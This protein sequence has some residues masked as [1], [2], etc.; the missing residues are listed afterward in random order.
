MKPLLLRPEAP[1]PAGDLR[2]K[3]E[4]ALGGARGRPL[5]SPRSA[6]MTPTRLIFG[7]LC[8]LATSCVPMTMSASPLAMASSSSRRRSRRPA[9]RK[10]G[11]SCGHPGSGCRSPRRCARCPDP[12][13]TRWS[14]RAAG[15]AGLGLGSD[16]RNG[17]DDLAAEAVFDQPGRAGRALESVAADAA[18]RQRRVA[19]AVEEEQR[20]LATLQRVA[21]FLQKHR[22]DEAATPRRRIAHVDGTKS[23]ASPHRQNAPAGRHARSGP[24]RH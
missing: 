20:L 10:T 21:R 22:R 1:G 2:Q 7:K 18:E 6:S 17:A 23:R 9:C 19:A 15:R 5:A 12:Q 11:R 8:P 14:E 13:A 3:L 16:D 24:A 4:G